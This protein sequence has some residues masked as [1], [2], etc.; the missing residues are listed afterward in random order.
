LLSKP[1]ICRQGRFGKVFF[2]TDSIVGHPFGSV[3]EIQKGGTLA[4]STEEVPDVMVTGMRAPP[5]TC[6]VLL[7]VR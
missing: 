5:S 3:F 4:L 7:Q 6:G 1:L 2:K